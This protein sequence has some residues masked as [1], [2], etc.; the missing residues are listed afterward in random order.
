MDIFALNP[1]HIHSE[2]YK[3]MF[4]KNGMNPKE[5]TLLI[6]IILFKYTRFFV[7]RIRLYINCGI[8]LSHFN[9]VFKHGG[10]RSFKYGSDFGITQA[11]L[12]AFERNSHIVR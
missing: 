10:L 8:S 3:C 4:L 6:G 9:E 1:N 7:I 5:N 11:V 12:P 2:Q